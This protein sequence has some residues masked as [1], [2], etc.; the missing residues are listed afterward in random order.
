MEAK[1]RIDGNCFPPTVNDVVGDDNDTA[2]GADVVAAANDGDVG[3]CVNAGVPAGFFCC[4]SD[5]KAD[6]KAW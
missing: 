4:C 1:G 6:H 5:T 3:D 2:S